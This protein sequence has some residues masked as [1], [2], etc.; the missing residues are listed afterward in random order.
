MNRIGYQDIS[1]FRAP[2]KNAYMAGFGDAA[3][4]AIVTKDSSGVKTLVPAAGIALMA[5]LQKSGLTVFTTAADKEQVIVVPGGSSVP[6]MEQHQTAMDWVNA[7]F[8][9]GR[10]V[11]VS[12]NDPG[13]LASVISGTMTG[14]TILASVSV[15]A[16]EV[17][18]ASMPNTALIAPSKLQA[19]LLSKQG[20]MDRASAIGPVGVAVVALAGAGVIYY[21]VK[22]RKGRR[23]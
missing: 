4:D 7:Q 23:A 6:F 22:G 19:P 16:D 17:A 2:Y 11:I 1:H 18:A 8:A 9:K 21:I 5:L 3:N 14:Q 10:D 20:V 13:G 15:K 12:T